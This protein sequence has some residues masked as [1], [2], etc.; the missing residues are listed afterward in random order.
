MS[1]YFSGKIK[2]KQ[3]AKMKKHFWDDSEPNFRSKCFGPKFGPKFAPN[4]FIQDIL[5][6]NYETQ[7]FTKF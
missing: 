3:L 2:L 1:S 4:F 7:A 5:I 6:Q